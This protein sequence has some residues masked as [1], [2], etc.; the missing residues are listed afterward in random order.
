MKAL[1]LFPLLVVLLSCERSDPAPAPTPAPTP[2]SEPTATPVPTPTPIPPPP[3]GPG[4]YKVGTDIQPGIYVVRSWDCHLERLRALAG[5][6]YRYYPLASFY[7]SHI[8]SSQL[9]SQFYVEVRADDDY[10]RT[11]CEVIPLAAWPVP[12][13]P[14]TVLESGIYLVGRDIL[15]GIY[16]GYE[17]WNGGDVF[18]SCPWTRL[19][20]VTGE[21]SRDYI[22]DWKDRR[23]RSWGDD[24]RQRVVY[25]VVQPSDYALHTSCL[26]TLTGLAHVPTPTPKPT[27]EP[28]PT[29][30]AI[31]L[32]TT[33][34]APLLV[35]VRNDSTHGITIEAFTNFSIGLSRLSLVVNDNDY[36]RCSKII[37]R[38]HA[39]VYRL[40]CPTIG[41]HIRDHETVKHISAFVRKGSTVTELKL[42]CGKN[43]LSSM[44]KSVFACNWPE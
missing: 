3:L 4:M 17:S 21:P 26:L 27:A 23:R 36:E 42:T 44:W 28:W 31:D 30:E 12:D 16:Y 5:P 32:A 13:K 24:E 20:G 6:T 8:L 15:P 35:V 43:R 39:N 38:F 11:D 19:S 29:R 37:Q 25:V 22:E 14:Y 2:T 40:Y 7:S 41:N 1:W 33:D 10:F 9:D 34:R 18:F